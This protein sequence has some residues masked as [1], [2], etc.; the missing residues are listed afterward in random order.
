M[1]FSDLA[2]AAE[3]YGQP[4]VAVASPNGIEDA[5]AHDGLRTHVP[6]DAGFAAPS[7]I[8]GGG[9]VGDELLG[10]G[11]YDLVAATGPGNGEWG[12]PA[13]LEIG[14]APKFFAGGLVE[15]DEGFAFNACVDEQMIAQQ[16]ERCGGAPPVEL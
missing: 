7:F 12:V 10:L 9:V 3:L 15:R 8:T 13:F 4:T 16:G 1:A 14:R 11:H 6:G 5:I 2:G